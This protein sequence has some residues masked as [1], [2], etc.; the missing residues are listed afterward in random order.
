M[1]LWRPLVP[2]VVGA[3]TWRVEAVEPFVCAGAEA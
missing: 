3:A 1:P 2:L